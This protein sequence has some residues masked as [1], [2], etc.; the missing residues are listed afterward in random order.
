MRI[1]KEFDP[2]KGRYCTCP[3]KFSLNPYTGCSFSCIYCYITSYIKNPNVVRLKDEVIEKVKKD[4]KSFDKNFYIMLS[5]SSDPYPYIEKKLNVTREI[6]KIFKEENIKVLI[7]TKSDIIIKD[8]DI[9]KD[10]N[11]VVTMTI[12][13]LDENYK[14]IEPF[15]PSPQRRL[16]AIQFLSENNISVAVRIDPII[17]FFND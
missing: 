16:N 13:T 2:W 4:L 17:P 1:I 15:A 11:V 7:V 14:L 3:K 6:L 10:M 9:L 8:I 5:N 12:T